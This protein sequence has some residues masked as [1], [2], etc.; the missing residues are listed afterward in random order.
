[1]LIRIGLLYPEHE[2]LEQN[3]NEIPRDVCC[4]GTNEGEQGFSLKILLRK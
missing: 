3:K 1:M 2:A 4:R